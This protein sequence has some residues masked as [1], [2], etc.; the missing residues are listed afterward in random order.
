[1][2]IITIL[3][4]ALGLS[5]DS[6]A[7]SLTCGAVQSRIQFKQALKVA[8]ILALFQGAFP[9]AG[10]YLGVSFSELVEPVDHWV[11]LILLSML[12]IRMIYGGISREEEE[13]RKDI[14]R[15]LILVIMGI[16][17]S[18]DAFVVGISLGFLDANIFLSA[19]LIGTI[20]FLASMLAILLGKNFGE[21]LGQ[22]VEIAGG[23]I[24]V[25]I[26]LKIVIEHTLFTVA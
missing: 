18:I 23:L 12:G 7:V 16:S 8:F 20:T 3:A 13:E 24:L 14:T 17:T 2:E 11:A 21:R 25:L 5:L 10:Y 19:V 26:G 1:M 15:P 4:I 9:L 6:F 22:G